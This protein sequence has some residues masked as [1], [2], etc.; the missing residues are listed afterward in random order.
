MM[1]LNAPVAALQCEVDFPLL[2]V[3]TNGM[4]LISLMQGL[5]AYWG[6]PGMG[7]PVALDCLNPMSM[8]SDL[9]S[10]KRTR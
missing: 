6:V 9:S 2:L 3:C 8:L 4:V 10:S 5:L 1:P 7:E